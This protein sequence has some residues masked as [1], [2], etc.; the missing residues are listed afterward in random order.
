MV[1][2]GRCLGIEFGFKLLQLFLYFFQ[3]CCFS[4][5]SKPA[6]RAFS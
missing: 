4:S 2:Q 3:T 5:Q 6:P 1:D